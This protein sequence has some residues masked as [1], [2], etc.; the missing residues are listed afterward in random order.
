MPVSRALRRLLGIR[1]LE[2]ELSRAALATARAELRRLDD[3]LRSAAQRAQQGRELI[4]ASIRGG[5][6]TDRLAGLE[7]SRISEQLSEVLS[8]SIA[9]A[10][11]R[12]DDLQDIYL[13]H[14]VE[15]RQAEA[16]LENAENEDT[17]HA[18]RQSQ[19]ELDEWFL[20]RRLAGERNGEQGQ[21]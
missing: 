5:D 18:E 1:Q 8:R 20:S 15:R 4:A 7:E 6:A 21:G 14:H 13:A 19:Q 12:V 2:E 9:S 16:L 10:A 11:G 3:A 17:A